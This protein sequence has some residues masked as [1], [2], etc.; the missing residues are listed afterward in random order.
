MTGDILVMRQNELKRLELVKKAIDKQITQVEAS[1]FL[2]MSYR[3][4][5]R[6]IKRVREI[7]AQGVIHQARGKFNVRRIKDV[8][9]A[10]VLRVYA[11][12][13]KDFGATL[14]SE[15]LAKHEGIKLSR[16][17]LRKWLRV[18]GHEAARRRGRKHRRWRERKEY[19]GQMGQMDGSHHEW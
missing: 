5:K 4:V 16:E 11:R 7:G 8:I 19:V 10:K 9:K 14:A 6:I 1:K 15:K 2:G 18:E 12:R 17:T 13:Y 3:Q